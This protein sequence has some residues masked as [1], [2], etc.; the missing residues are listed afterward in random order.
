M[1]WSKAWNSNLRLILK[2]IYE[3]QTKM[4]DYILKIR[5]KGKINKSSNLLPV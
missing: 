4:A 5:V 2:Q 3:I 1:V